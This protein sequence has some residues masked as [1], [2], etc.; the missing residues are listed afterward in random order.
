MT[1]AEHIARYFAKLDAKEVDAIESLCLVYYEKLAL[2]ARRRFGSF[3]LRVTDE[4]SVANDVLQSFHSRALSGEFS[5]IRKPE[6]L[7]LLLARLTR[8][9]VVDEIRR[10]TAQKRGSGNTRGNS[11]FVPVAGQPMVGDF[12]RFQAEQETPSTKQIWAEEMHQLLGKLE[13]PVLC[14]I[15]VLRYEGFT[16]EEIAEQ[17]KVSVATVE[18]KRRRIRERL[19]HE[20]FHGSKYRE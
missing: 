8:D 11:I 18:R 6:K 9:R 20:P 16:N 15:L 12:D 5:D 2:I 17:L 3:P 7:L 14:T 13:D 10:H 1:D 4:Y 19:S